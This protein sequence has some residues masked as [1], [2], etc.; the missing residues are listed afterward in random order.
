MNGRSPKPPRR[1][2]SPN[3]PS[4][5]MLKNRLLPVDI[6]T[7]DVIATKSR[8]CQLLHI[9]SQSGVFVVGRRVP[10]L[11]KSSPA[12]FQPPAYHIC[13]AILGRIPH[14]PLHVDP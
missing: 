7:I 1:A 9:A 10:S 6:G 4:L 11:T 2:I 5:S 14:P 8:T 3:L 13:R 12:R